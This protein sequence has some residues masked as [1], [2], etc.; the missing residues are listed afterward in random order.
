VNYPGK[1]V[2]AS[3]KAKVYDIVKRAGGLTSV[4]NIEGVKIKRP[5]QAKQI[6]VE[7]I[8]LNLGKKDSIQNKLEKTKEDLKYAIIP[9]TGSRLLKT[10]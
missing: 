1:Y 10:R 3:K 9:R 7:S 6:E 4:A 2:L 5:I 8:N